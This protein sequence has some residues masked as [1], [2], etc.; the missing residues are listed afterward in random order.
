MQPSKNI[1]ILKFQCVNWSSSLSLV[2]SGIQDTKTSMLPKES[3]RQ[4]QANRLVDAPWLYD[5]HE[6]MPIP[7]PETNSVLI[8]SQ[9]K[10]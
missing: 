4:V 8:I 7:L 6:H 9:N 10:R 2:L 1:Y 3:P 5:R